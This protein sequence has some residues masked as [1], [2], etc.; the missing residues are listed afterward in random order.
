[1]IQSGLQLDQYKILRLLGSG[2][3]ADVYE[4]TDTILNRQVAI[5]I[6]PPTLSRNPELMLRF[7]KE[8]RAAASLN[9]H[10]IVTVYDVGRAEGYD[11][12]AMRLLTGGD[13]R[14]RIDQGLQPLQAMTILR[15]VADA[16]AHAH[17]A[18]I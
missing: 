2:G 1:M 5:K 18:G 4:A 9:H 17:Q 10:G 6:L 3:M 14:R 8:V 12:Y 15:E 11:Y 13:L 16:F 7:Q